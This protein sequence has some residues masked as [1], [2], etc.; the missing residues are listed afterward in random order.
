MSFHLRH[1]LRF[2]GPRGCRPLA[3]AYVGAPG[4]GN[5]PLGCIL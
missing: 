4:Q 3:A 5:S 2:R 1:P